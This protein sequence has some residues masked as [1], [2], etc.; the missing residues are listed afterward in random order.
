L[1]KTAVPAAALLVGHAAMGFVYETEQEFLS[2]GD[3]DGDGKPDLVIVDRYSGRVR[4]G[5][6]LE[7]GRFDWVDWRAGGAK[8][9]ASVSVGK[10][11]DLKRDSVA[12]ASADANLIT[13]V[14]AANPALPSDPVPVRTVALGP[15]VVMA[16][17]VG[18]QGNTPLHDLLVASIYNSDPTPN[19]VTLFRNNGKTFTQTTEIPASGPGA[20]ANRITLKR[21]GAELGAGIV[22]EDTGNSLII[23]TLDSG[24]PVTLLAIPEVPKGADYVLGNFRG[25]PLKEIIFYK[26]GEPTLT[27][28]TLAE[29]DGK[30]QAG[31]AR[32]IELGRP[33]RQLVVVEGEKKS[34]LLGIFGDEEPAEVMNFDCVNPPVTVQKLAGVTNYFLNAG[35]ALPD[36]V[37]LF[38]VIT[39]DRP[40]SVSHYQIHLL[41]GD[42]YEPGAYGSLPTLA[43][44]DDTTVPEIHKR[45]V[46][47]LTVKSP[48]EMKPY[49]NTIPGTA[50]T[51]EMVPIAGGEFVMGSPDAEKD[52]KPDEGP[53]HKVKISP[54][55]MGRYEVTWDQYLLFMYPDDE[56]KLRE[57]HATPEEVNQ[58]SDA[59]TRPSKPYVDMSFGMGKSA[60]S[61]GKGFPAIA[62]TQHGANKF[63]HWLSAKT[64]HFYRLP[65]E[66]E[67]E[68]A[69]RA[70]TTTAYSFGDDVDK[71]PEY[72][73]CFDNSNSK[74]QEVGKKKPNPWGLYD[75]HGN[76]TEWVLDQMDADYY[77]L[78]AGKGEVTDPWNKA[79]KPYPHAARGGSWDDDPPALRSAARRAS[80]RSWKMQDPQLPKSIWYLTDAQI[81]GF[82]IVRPLKVPPPEELLK[83]WTSGVEKD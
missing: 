22:T 75:M 83:Y 36:A 50:V 47:D 15:N 58:I 43:D 54:F 10:L 4:L 81:V 68:Y 2:T 1:Q 61:G 33:V 41:N 7:P 78:C 34:R 57:T 59:V 6:Q 27:V 28:R 70:G 49:T 77:K 35:L 80:D 29:A 8:D 52:R 53:P 13:V 24:Q 23:G 19:R 56:K 76:V 63:C 11:A 60:K 14:D 3:F 64:G 82:R 69:C 46:A 72:A 79:T 65:S 32:T 21:G 45:I 62:M 12:I 67:W 16:I 55:W 26:Y 17:D 30:F 51:Y 66:A 42:S 20:R 71:L 31:A 18:G 48:A 73:W 25:E 39:N 5:Y 9:V 37:L 44:R 74:Y 38:S 40:R